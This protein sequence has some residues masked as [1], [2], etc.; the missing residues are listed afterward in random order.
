MGDK[1]AALKTLLALE[2][3]KLLTRP[4]PWGTCSSRSISPCVY[5]CVCDRIILFYEGFLLESL[6]D[7]KAVLSCL[8]LSPSPLNHSPGVC[9]DDASAPDAGS[10]SVAGIGQS[11]VTSGPLD[12]SPI[13]GDVMAEAT[14]EVVGKEDNG[15]I[16]L[17]QLLPTLL[18]TLDSPAISSM[19]TEHSGVFQ[20]DK[21][22]KTQKDLQGQILAAASI[23]A[24][25][26]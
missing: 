9:S 18:K 8:S 26:K 10:N 14:E 3:Y 22:G 17:N 20:T 11:D 5:A 19:L 15:D 16:L 13:P 7:W 21:W 1:N 25:Q 2:D 23:H 4:Q 24:Q 12:D 6:E